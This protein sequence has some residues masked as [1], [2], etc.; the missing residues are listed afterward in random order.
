MQSKSVITAAVAG[1]CVLS[2]LF[3]STEHSEVV[4]EAAVVEP[5]PIGQCGGAHAI[6]PLDAAQKDEYKLSHVS[7]VIR[8]GDRTRASYPGVFL[9][10]VNR[11]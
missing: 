7:V 3:L 1:L 10:L 9:F 8:H 11:E 5:A 6:P 2:V 4:L